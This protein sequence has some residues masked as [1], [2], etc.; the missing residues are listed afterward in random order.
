LRG[1]ATLESVGDGRYYVKLGKDPLRPIYAF[2]DA[3]NSDIPQRFKLDLR[4]RA[5]GAITIPMA[6]ARP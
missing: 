6:E 1:A 3:I 2:Q 4:D 5:M